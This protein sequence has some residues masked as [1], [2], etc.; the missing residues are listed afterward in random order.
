MR[1]PHFA[2]LSQLSVHLCV[3]LIWVSSYQTLARTKSDDERKGAHPTS[4][5]ILPDGCALHSVS[6]FHTFLYNTLLQPTVSPI[7]V[8]RVIVFQSRLTFGMSRITNS[9]NVVGE[10]QSTKN[11]SALQFSSQLDRH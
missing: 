9:K 7:Y 3:M 10:K 11:E 1:V 4:I 6:F 2:C 5:L 8:H